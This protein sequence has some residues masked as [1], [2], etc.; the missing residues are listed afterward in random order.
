MSD[1]KRPM[2]YLMGGCAAYPDL[3][4][5][6]RQ[7]AA[8]AIQDAGGE[9]VWPPDIYLLSGRIEADI[10]PKFDEVLA[11]F[12]IHAP[13]SSRIQ[14]LQAL[15][16]SDAIFHFSEKSGKGTAAEIAFNA[17][18]PKPRPIAEAKDVAYFRQ[19]AEEVVGMGRRFRCQR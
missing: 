18:L 12:N 15:Y 13:F 17:W 14:S 6:W 16:S 11:E 7:E 3:G 10:K 2:I 9:A 4:V 8:K 1:F 5:A 19:I